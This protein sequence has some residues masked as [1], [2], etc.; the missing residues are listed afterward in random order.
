MCF[1]CT[2][3]EVEIES[4]QNLPRVVFVLGGP[5]SGKGTQCKKLI[6]KKP[7]SF[8]H[9]SAGDCLREERNNPNSEH[10]DLIN[11]CIAEGSLVPVEITIKLLQKKIDIHY[12]QGMYVLIDG[13]PRNQD[14]YDGWFRVMTDKANVKFALFLD[15]SEDFMK[16]RLLKRGQSSG[17]T[18]DNLEVI[19]K[20]FKTYN[21]QT[22]PIVKLFEEQ[23]MLKTVSAEGTIDEVFG[24]VL[25]CFNSQ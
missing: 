20:R 10:G 25:S 22:M 7:E 3:D 15:I 18:D 21:D 24:R 14:N 19:K 11:T 1:F 4:K 9:I 17:R 6:E 23:K 16:E 2:A 12:K 8:V 5:G 13:F